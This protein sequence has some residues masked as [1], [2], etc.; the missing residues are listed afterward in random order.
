[1]DFAYTFDGEDLGDRIKRQGKLPTSQ[2]VR[3]VRQVCRALAAAHAEGIVHRDIKPANVFVCRYGLE[4]DFV[5]VLDFG[6]VKSRE[7]VDGQDPRLTAENVAGGTPA[8]MA[9]EQAAAD[10]H[11][12]Q[13]VDTQTHLLRCNERHEQQHTDQQESQ[14]SAAAAIRWARGFSWD[15][16]ARQTEALLEESIQ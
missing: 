16:A 1:M 2:A 13:R 6:L 8:Y 4:A 3:I 15:D 11:L 9:P 12:D 14:S 5:K 10:P 7:E